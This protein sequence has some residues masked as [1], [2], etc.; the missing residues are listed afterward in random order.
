ML[1]NENS[2]RIAVS[3]A[4]SLWTISGVSVFIVIIENAGAVI[5]AVVRTT[6]RSITVFP[7]HPFGKLQMHPCRLLLSKTQVLIGNDQHLDQVTR[8]L[9]CCGL[10][11]QMPTV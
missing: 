5:H 3:S 8:K 4:V 6:H 2:K 9:G 7:L 10:L 11:G 1:A